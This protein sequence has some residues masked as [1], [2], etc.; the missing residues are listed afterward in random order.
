MSDPNFGAKMAALRRE[1][2]VKNPGRP[3][4]RQKY[5]RQVASLERRF[6]DALPELADEYLAEL[7]TRMPEMCAEHRRI[8]RCP[9]HGCERQSERTA[10]DFRAVQY[11]VDR[12]MGRPVSRSEGALQVSFVQQMTA[13]FVDAF[14][15][16][17]DIPDPH[18]RRE[19]FAQRLM[20]VGSAYGGQD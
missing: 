11:V 14:T 12:I 7:R 13:A 20:L 9:V 18:E 15:A 10:F 4:I 3:A 19:Q 5:D 16:T 17:N 6:A 2:G 8:L 1:R